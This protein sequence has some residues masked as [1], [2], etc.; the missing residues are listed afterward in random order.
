MNRE[1]GQPLRFA[2]SAPAD[3]PAALAL[4]LAH[5]EPAARERTIAKL[6]SLPVDALPGTVW[7]AYRGERL[8]G[9][10]RATAG[11]GRA[12]LVTPPAIAPGEPET[13]AGELLRHVLGALRGEGVE[14]VQAVLET[15]R[16]ADIERLT[17]GG[18]RYVTDLLY[19]VSLA[20]TF[21]DAPPAAHLE[22]ECYRASEHTRLVRIVERTYAGSLDCPALES[23][24]SVEDVLAGYRASRAF[25]P[26]GWLLV[27]SAGQDVGCLLLAD[28]A[29]LGQWEL[30][31]MGVVPEARG[32]G[33]GLAMTRHAQWLARGAGRARLVLAVDEA[34][35]PAKDAYAAAGFVAWDHR[36]VLVR[37]Q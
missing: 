26:K 2:P 10:L 16:R 1:S 36:S 3:E 27:K 31:Y 23:A 28:D 12:A 24:R 6:R 19:L 37:T 21:P 30:T 20:G 18:F 7:A 25:D 9:A 22:F 33:F 14:L 13:T 4:L 11:A 35:A 32:Q 29:A 5:L 15:D 34:N 17:A 8:V